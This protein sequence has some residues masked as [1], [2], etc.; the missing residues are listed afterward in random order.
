MKITLT[1]NT[2]L[3]SITNDDTLQNNAYSLFQPLILK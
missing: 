3:R 2:V 1:Y